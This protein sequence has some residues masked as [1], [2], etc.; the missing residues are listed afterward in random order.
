MKILLLIL[1]ILLGGVF[2]FSAL[3]KLFPIEIFELNF[4]YQGIADWEL[5]PYL[6]RALIIVELF[7]GLAL[8]FNSLLKELVLPATFILLLLFS[9]YLVYSI[10][11]DGNAGNCGCF[12]TVLPMSPLQS[13]VKNIVL[14]AA[15]VFIYIKTPNRE[16][17]Y[18]LLLPSLFV[19]SSAPIVLLFPIY[20]YSFAPKKLKGELVEIASLSNFKGEKNVNLKEGK[21]LVAIFNMACSHCVEVALKL[22]AAK[23]RVTLPPTYFI[24]MGDSSEVNE[25]Y[26]L[27]NSSAPYLLMNAVDFIKRYQSGWPRVYLLENGIIKYDNDYKSFNGR[28]F[29]QTVTDFIKN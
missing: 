22:N 25:F 10:A 8:I 23:S 3:S 24:L 27:T 21:K 5:A 6:A 2:I 13:L 7:L 16:W 1:R 11:K 12:G 17:K 4:V 9:A 19:L 18:K 15:C 26:A 28:D 29:E 14:I 20:D